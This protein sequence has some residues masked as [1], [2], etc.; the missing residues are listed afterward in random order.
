MTN[1]QWAV[2]FADIEAAAER[3]GGLIRRT[4]VLPTS[5]L[6]DCD[7]VSVSLKCENLQWGSAFKA[8][9]ATNAVMSLSAEQAA[10]G[11]VTHSSGNHA[12]A[13]ARAALQRGIAAHIVMPRNSAAVKLQAVRQLGIEPIL[14]ES[15]AA[16]R[17]AAAAEVQQRTGAV[18]VH[19]FNDPRV[20][21]GQGTAAL[22]ILEQ[23]PDLQDLIVPVGGG[24]LLAGTLLAIRALRPE[25]RVFGAEPEWADDARRSLQSGR[26]EPALRTDSIADGL[27]TPL[28]SLTFPIIQQ[29]VTDILLAGE[30][31]IRAATG[32]LAAV[33]RLVAEPSGA[34]PLAVLQQHAEMFRGRRV[35]VLISG[36]NLDD[37]GLISGA[38][39]VSSQSP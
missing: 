33:C 32:H 37:A 13:L 7:A 11:V 5:G 34:V 20:I 19:P 30:T 16:A 15:T 25:V 6:P 17:E 1:E 23:C 28:G 9:G 10:C 12:A 22:E 27:R 38:L 39:T 36:G 21:A 3:L 8:R 18:L 29:L 2:T 24:G 26:I 35:V 14:C 4:P 31:Q